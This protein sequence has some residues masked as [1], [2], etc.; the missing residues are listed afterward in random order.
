MTDPTGDDADVDRTISRQFNYI[1]LVTAP[2]YVAIALVLFSPFP[3]AGWA[4]L[5]VGVVASAVLIARATGWVR[6]D[7][8]R[9]RKLALLTV[10]MCAMC[11]LVALAVI[12]VM[13]D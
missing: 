9:L 7:N 3:V 5:F 13:A 2:A 6:A 1:A 11:V 4:F 12:L 8:P 10:G